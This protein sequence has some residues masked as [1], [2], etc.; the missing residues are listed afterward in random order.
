MEC[1]IVTEES[2]SNRIVPLVV[3]SEGERHIIGTAEVSPDGTVVG[4]LERDRG[5]EV[6]A[7]IS[8][9]SMG[10]GEVSVVEVTPAPAKPSLPERIAAGDR[11]T[12]DLPE[13][14]LDHFNI[15]DKEEFK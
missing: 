1:S 2:P 8:A 10:F 13:E 11:F 5:H 4:R 6:V 14:L 15:F 7:E 9:F 12:V 3:Y